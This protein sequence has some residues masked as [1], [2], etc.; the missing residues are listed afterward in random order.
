MPWKVGCRTLS[1]NLLHGN[2][3]FWP[4]WGRFSQN[5]MAQ[6]C[7]IPRTMETGRDAGRHVSSG[8][9]CRPEDVKIKVFQGVLSFL[10]FR[11]KE[12]P[13]PGMPLEESGLPLCKIIF[14]LGSE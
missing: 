6:W 9:C 13:A 1:V 10:D 4:Q 7:H 8:I 12:E 14:K 3:Y 11:G 5:L 2:Q